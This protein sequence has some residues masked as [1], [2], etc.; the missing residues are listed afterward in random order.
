MKGF[1]SILLLILVKLII[2]I[3]ILITFALYNR[4]V[5]S[6]V[7]FILFFLKYAY[8]Q[9]SILTKKEKE[10]L[11]E[12]RAI[13]RKDVQLSICDKKEIK[14]LIIEN[15]KTNNYEIIH[16]NL[17]FKKYNKLIYHPFLQFMHYNILEFVYIDQD[18]YYKYSSLKSKIQQLLNVN[19]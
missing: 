19:I 1:D 10:W 2:F 3:L 13:S 15:L 14:N 8:P 17:N 6:F 16:S 5:F 12:H 7:I 11:N 9:I 4:L 18:T